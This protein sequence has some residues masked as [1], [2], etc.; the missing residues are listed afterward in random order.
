MRAAVQGFWRVFTTKTA[1]RLAEFY[2][3]E[4]TIWS[5]TSERIELGRL[6]ILRRSREYLAGDADLRTSIKGPIEVMLYGDVAVACYTFEFYADRVSEATHRVIKE[7]ITCGR[8][9]Q[10][11]WKHDDREFRIV[12]EHFSVPANGQR[13]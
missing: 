3:P 5:S 6:A 13:S 12:H 2:A 11:F 10:V 1:D 4:A 8:A 9:T 7:R